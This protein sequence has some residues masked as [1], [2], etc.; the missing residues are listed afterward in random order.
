MSYSLVAGQ[1]AWRGKPLAADPTTFQ[2]LHPWI[3]VDASTVFLH[4]KPKPLERQGFCIL[5]P[6]HAKNTEHV[7]WI[8][9]RSLKPLKNVDPTRFRVLGV[10]YGTDGTHHT[11]EARSLRLKKGA[12]PGALRELGPH[13]AVDDRAL[14]HGTTQVPLDGRFDPSRLRLHLCVDHAVNL[15]PTVLTDGDRHALFDGEWLEL[16]DDTDL[17]AFR[18]LVSDGIESRFFTD[19]QQVYLRV[20][21]LRRWPLAETRAVGPDLLQTSDGWWT[22]TGKRAPDG[23]WVW[24][25]DD[26]YLVDG[27]CRTPFEAGPPA[28]SLEVRDAGTTA[29]RRLAELFFVVLDDHEPHRVVPCD[30]PYTA[31][32]RVP[33]F[34]VVEDGNEVAI[35]MAGAEV[36]RSTASDWMHL[37]TRVW[38]VARGRADHHRF[39]PHPHTFHA[40]GTGLRGRLLF[41]AGP[42]VVAWTA[43]L[44]ERGEEREAGRLVHQL[45]VDLHARRREQLAPV[46]GQLPPTL[47]PYARGFWQATE[48]LEVTTNLGVLKALRDQGWLEHPDER[49]RE[50]VLATLHGAIDAVAKP[51]KAQREVLAYLLDRLEA[52]TVPALRSQTLGV[53]ELLAHRVE[54]GAD[55]VLVERL[56]AEGV[57][58]PVPESS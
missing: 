43:S 10:A 30:L 29:L 44:V 17:P 9:E 22:S 46:L 45:F 31:S 19:V 16:P 14:Y 6:H 40:S 26:T 2:A 49:V 34:E 18:P 28:A 12:D 38:A 47:A 27:N 1:P 23:D 57:G 13:Y 48:H 58:L 42:R 33:S 20:P 53:L 55:R 3:A 39:F 50:R 51:V 37:L 56:A 41:H 25:T 52:E 54:D 32:A 24:L 11:F 7:F 36:V 35:R 8:G 5:G 15:G 4:G 21:P